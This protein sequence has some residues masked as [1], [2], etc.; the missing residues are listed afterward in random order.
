V[1]AEQRVRHS[2]STS[3]SS[4]SSGVQQQQ[5]QQRQ[6]STSPLCIRCILMFGGS[7]SWLGALTSGM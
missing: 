7:V 5:Q 2:S 4:S 6:Q 3:S 1:L